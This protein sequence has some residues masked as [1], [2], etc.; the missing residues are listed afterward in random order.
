MPKGM[1]QRGLTE[2]QQQE[3]KEAFDLFD[4]DKSGQIDFKELKAAF[5]A[6]GFQVPK[7]ELKKMFNDVDTD[8][9]GE[10]EFPEVCC[11]A[12]A[13]PVHAA[14]GRVPRRPQRRRLR[15][16]AGRA[17][18]DRP[19]A[20]LARGRPRAR[21][22]DHGDCR[23]AATPSRRRHTPCAPR[24]PLTPYPACARCAAAR[25]RSSCR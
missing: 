21:G 1:M 13:A 2:E 6:L 18:R 24:T 8:G 3:L 17:R 23:G 4:A 9:S 25:V 15:G 5:K 12:T 22:R 19:A 10:I 14:F 7:E 20:T 11:L 16:R